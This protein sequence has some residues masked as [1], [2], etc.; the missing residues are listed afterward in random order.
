MSKVVH[1]SGKRKAATARVTIKEGKGVIRINKLLLDHYKPFLAK[2]KIQEPLILAGDDI[3]KK[4][5]IDVNVKGGGWLGQCEASRLAIA[6]G[7]VQF[8]GSKKLEK[9]F[10]DYDR[11]LLVADVR[12]KEPYK[13]NDSKARAKRQKS[14][15]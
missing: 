12:F 7:L 1:I 14:Y 6:K 5:N 10:L 13:P 3:V 11:N 8:T 4:V 2:A 9:T 15:R